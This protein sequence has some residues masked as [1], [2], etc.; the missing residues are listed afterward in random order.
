MQRLPECVRILLWHVDP[1]SV[2]TE[3]H[4]DYLM[5]RVMTRGSW[6]AMRWLS[7][8][9]SRAELG[10]FVRRKGGQLSPRIQAWFS[11]SIADLA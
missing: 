8:T 11:R 4:R 6:E 5:E 2:D 1:G 3:A 7:R 9:Y 10:D